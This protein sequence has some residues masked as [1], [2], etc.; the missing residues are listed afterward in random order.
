MK[1]GLIQ[2]VVSVFILGMVAMPLKAEVGYGVKAGGELYHLW[3]PDFNL[4]SPKLGFAGGVFMKFRFLKVLGIQPEILYL[5]KGGKYAESK[6]G[7]I[8]NPG[9]TPPTKEI[10]LTVTRITQYSN[11]EFPLL[12]KLYAPGFK[13]AAPHLLM[14]PFY[15]YQVGDREITATIAGVNGTTPVTRSDFANPTDYDGLGDDAQTKG[16]DNL[17]EYGVVFGVGVDFSMGTVDIRYAIGFSDIEKE[18]APK[19]DLDK[20]KT[21]TVTVLFGFEF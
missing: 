12:F 15:G 17:H 13:E 3:D 6:K 20:S 10:P 9:G 21:G 2:S 11:I 5:T 19:Q 16:E 1:K 8:N 4:S 14:G 7:I 18:A